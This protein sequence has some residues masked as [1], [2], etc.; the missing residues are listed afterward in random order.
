MSPE[1]KSEAGKSSEDKSEAGKSSEDKSEAGKSS[2]DK[3]AARK[4]SE[5]KSE[6]RKSSED[7]DK[8]EAR[9]SSED[10]SETRKSSEDKSEAR[11]SSDDKSEA[12]KS[13]EDKSEARKS[14]EDKSEARKL[15]EDKDKSEARKSSEDKSEARKLFEDKSEARKSFED[16]SG[17]G[18]STHVTDSAGSFLDIR[19]F[20]PGV[21]YLLNQSD[22]KITVKNAGSTCT[23]Y[24]MFTCDDG[25]TT[26]Q[27]TM[28]C[29]FHQHCDDNSDE[30]FCE[31]PPCHGFMCSNDQVFYGHY[32][33]NENFWTSSVVCKVAGFL[34]CLSS[35][36][37]VLLAWFITMNHIIVI[38]F[39]ETSWSSDRLFTIAA[40]TLSWFVGTLLSLTPFLPGLSSWGLRGQSGLCR[41]A[42]FDHYKSGDGFK[43]I[44]VIVTVNFILCT[45][46]VVG[47]VIM[48]IRIPKKNEKYVDS[49]YYVTPQ[50]M[51]LSDVISGDAVSGYRL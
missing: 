51:F 46:T 42:V 26:V 45:M 17:G 18:T 4:S 7:K 27:H 1:D 24:P 36:V 3:S 20:C 35:E 11:K 16:K 5:D 25:T 50:G 12:Q 9:K 21:E 33:H 2:E 48:S 30:S 37:S 40:C 15:S 10:K 23:S 29:D 49:G 32:F 31:H 43:W 22:T 39:L 34:S 8:S 41:L 28:V 38:C 47:H 13:S 19:D 44:T 6:A 14:S